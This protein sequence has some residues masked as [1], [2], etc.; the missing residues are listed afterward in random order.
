[1]ENRGIPAVATGI[2]RSKLEQ[3]WAHT[4]VDMGI[5]FIYEPRR[6]GS[7]LPD[8]LLNDSNALLEIKPTREIADAELPN[9]ISGMFAAYK[10]GHDIA[11]IVGGPRGSIM[12][13]IYKFADVTVADGIC[14]PDYQWKPTVEDFFSGGGELM[15]CTECHGYFFIGLHTWSCRCCGAY[16][17]DHYL[18]SVQLFTKE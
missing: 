10:Q 15:R 18:E 8:F 9:I 1:L 5:P 11:A 16:D 4:F 12:P 7:W 17:G 3:N 14:L 6:Y 2:Y 13:E